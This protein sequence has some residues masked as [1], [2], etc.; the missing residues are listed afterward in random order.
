MRGA[1]IM[2]DQGDDGNFDEK[3]L[4]WEFF[5]L[6]ANQRLIFFRFIIGLLV[7]LFV[8]YFYIYEKGARSFFVSLVKDLLRL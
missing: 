3:R 5:K 4:V 7:A 2:S 1:T 8:S 6:Q